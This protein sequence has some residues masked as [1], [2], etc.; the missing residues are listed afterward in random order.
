MI[1]SKF[2][3]V[4]ALLIP[5]NNYAQNIVTTDDLQTLVGEWTGSLTYMDYSTNNP[6]TMPANV[7]VQKGKKNNQFILN[8]NYP[9]E[10]NAN[11]KD[12][13]KLSKDGKQ[14][15]NHEINSKVELPNGSIQITTQYSGKDN[16]KKALIKNIYII[17]TSEFIIRKEVKFEN[18]TDWLVRNE[19]TFSR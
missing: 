18:S 19:Y 1:H 5:L 6:Y 7:I 12:K 14:L 15:N 16:G 13:I 4:I 3:I 8:I 9:K 2:F 10:A 11:S 17:G